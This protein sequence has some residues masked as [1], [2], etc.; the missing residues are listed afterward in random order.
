M[1]ETLEQAKSNL[2]VQGFLKYKDL[3]IPQGEELKQAILDLKKEKNAVILAHYYQPG[4]IQDIADFLGDSLQL[5]RQAKETNADMI[6][7]CGV[8]FMA[9]AAKI[10]NPTKKVV[11]PDTLA[12]C[13]LADGCSGEG[14]RKMREQHPDALIATYINCNAETKA[15]SDIIV[16]SSNAETI[17]KAL[18]TDRPIIFAPDKNLGRYLSKK[19]G[20]DMILWDGSCIVH[21]AFS[22]E[23]IAQQLADHP[24]AKLIAHPESETPVLDLAQF[25]GSTS[26]LLD[27]VQK[28]DCQEFIIATEEG[29]LHEMKKRAPHKTL[30]PALVFDESCNCSECFYMKRNTME[31]LYLCM[32]YELPE[33]L[34]DEE[35]RLK[36]LKPIEAMLDLSKSI[37]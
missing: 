22:M 17:I 9:E 19:T 16:T 14:L 35:L 31:K 3:I 33:I 13:S 32:K 34:I 27:Y 15:E 37:K 28:D 24:N 12:G 18:P 29:I 26:A 4:E 25:I 36:A 1:N 30:I 20:R 10:L 21:E 23:R 2:P 6:A 5:A 7:F 11:L 8:H